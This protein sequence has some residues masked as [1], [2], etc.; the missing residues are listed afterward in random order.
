MPIRYFIATAL[1]AALGAA[2]LGSSPLV[3]LWGEANWFLLAFLTIVA[4]KAGATLGAGVCF[5]IGL[6]AGIE[7]LQED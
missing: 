6:A 7:T 5:M 1:G 3:M 2:L 4:M